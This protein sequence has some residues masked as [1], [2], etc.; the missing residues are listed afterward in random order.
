[1]A[2][3]EIDNASAPKKALQA[4][5]VIYQAS[6]LLS[7]ME[8]AGIPSL[9]V[10]DM[11]IK[12]D[13]TRGIAGEY[14]VQ[15]DS[16]VDPRKVAYTQ[17]KTSLKW[18]M[19]PYMIL[20]SAKLSSREPQRL[21]DDNVKSASE[22]FAAVKDYVTLAQM[23]SFAKNSAAATA[24]WSASGAEVDTDVIAALQSIDANSNVQDGEK[25]SVI[26]PA[27][28]AREPQKLTLIKNIQRSMQDYLEKSFDVQFYKYRPYTNS[29]GTAVHDGLGNDALVF[30]QGKDTALQLSYD[31]AEAT[32]RKIRLIDYEKVLGRGDSYLQK[33]AVGCLPIWDGVSTFTSATDYKTTRI[34]K[35][36]GVKS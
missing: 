11:D 35:I 23:K 3:G 20:E 9:S 14:D 6:T 29:S 5:G 19:Y 25:I 26:V 4:Q 31:R 22:Y 34:Y 2:T 10:K 7:V 30:V 13:V 24:E 27:K 15:M 16:Y 33:M 28:V 17:I 21:W 1:M 18:T 12:W 32:R 8:R 36:T